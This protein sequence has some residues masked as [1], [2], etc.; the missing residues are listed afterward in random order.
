MTLGAQTN[1][2]LLGIEITLFGGVLALTGGSG[3]G[4]AVGVI[5]LVVAVSAFFYEVTEPP[6]A[7]PP[8]ERDQPSIT[9]SHG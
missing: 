4:F 3:P 1:R 2:V 8:V 5:G 9:E 7:A 6:K